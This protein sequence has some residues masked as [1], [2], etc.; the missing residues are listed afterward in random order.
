M[1][2]AEYYKGIIVKYA[3]IYKR[4][5]ATY[6]HTILLSDAENLAVYS[7]LLSIK[8]HTDNIISTSSTL[9]S[10]LSFWLRLR[11]LKSGQNGLILLYM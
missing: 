7:T 10:Q 8:L 11:F 9:R 5:M 4:N 2:D 1:D 6:Q 3:E